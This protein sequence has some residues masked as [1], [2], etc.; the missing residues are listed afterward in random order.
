METGGVSLRAAALATAAVVAVEAA[1]RRAGAAAGIEPLAVTAAA[2]LL[3]LALLAAL[4]AG[5]GLSWRRHFG[6]GRGSIRRGLGRGLLWSAGFGL[7]AAAALGALAAAGLDPLA[8]I[9]P[10]R[11]TPAAGL[12][13][14]LIVGGFLGPLAEELYFRGFVY[15][16]LRRFGAATAILSSTALFTA[17][18]PA[19]PALP[20]APIVGGL[21]FAGAYEIEKN[22][23]VPV[24][25]HVAGNIAL[26]TLP[27]LI[28]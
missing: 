1:A 12:P 14:L 17:L 18:H 23:L 20:V 16:A 13:R 7:A 22:L 9:N 27:L 10:G 4:A 19:G 24:V 28:A 26:F 11:P 5:C 2:R 21:L 8:L 25:L 6:I 3:D 15:G